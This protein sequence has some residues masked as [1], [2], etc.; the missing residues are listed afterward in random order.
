[1]I[2]QCLLDSAFHPGTQ[3]A[4]AGGSLGVLGQ[5]GKHSEILSQ[6]KER[7]KEDMR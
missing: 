6:K 4:E 5:S 2:K 7:K 3:E 1:M